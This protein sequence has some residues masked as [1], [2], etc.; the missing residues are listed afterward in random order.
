MTPFLR[1][2]AT[3]V[4]VLSVRPGLAFRSPMLPAQ[5]GRGAVPANRCATRVLAPALHAGKPRCPPPPCTR[6]RPLPSQPG[7]PSP[8]PACWRVCLQLRGRVHVHDLCA[9]PTPAHPS[10]C[11]RKPGRFVTL[12]SNLEFKVKLVAT[13]HV[14]P[15]SQ[16]PAPTFA[17]FL[18]DLIPRESGS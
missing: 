16:L 10:K 7:G 11:C 17:C 3:R 5:D 14:S 9:I 13:T 18:K 4:R 12:L 1:P 2:A 15:T 8:L 6:H